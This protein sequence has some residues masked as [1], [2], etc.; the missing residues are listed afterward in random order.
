MKYFS[1]N[2]GLIL[3][4]HGNGLFIDSYSLWTREL[5]EHWEKDFYPDNWNSVDI[6]R[7]EFY[8]NH[9]LA[10]NV[11]VDNGKD[12]L[13]LFIYFRNIRHLRQMRM[14]ISFII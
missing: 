1:G 2:N 14:F 6:H 5:I 3:I 4:E 11:E 12:I 8:S 10:M 13:D 9:Y 7:I